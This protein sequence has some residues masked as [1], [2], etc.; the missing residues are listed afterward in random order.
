MVTIDGISTT[1]ANAQRL[2]LI[3]HD[4]GADRYENVSA[5][6]LHEATGTAQ[7]ERE[8][9]AAQAAQ[10]ADAE[11]ASLNVHPVPEIEASHTSFVKSVPVSDQI[12]AIVQLQNTGK[13]QPA[14]LNRVAE[15]MQVQPDVAIDQLNAMSMGVQAQFKALARSRGVDPDHAADWTRTNRSQHVMAALQRHALGRDVVGGWDGLIA[16]YKRAT[17][18]ANRG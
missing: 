7:Q 9:A 10:A 2:G 4:K 16:D 12:G 18:G 15:A 17:Q 1:V 13:L 11:R 8:A 3:T 5:S 14:L 6:Q